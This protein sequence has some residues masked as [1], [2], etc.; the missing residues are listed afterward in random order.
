MSSTVSSLGMQLANSTIL[1]SEQANMS[2]LNGQL[3][4]GKKSNDLAEYTPGEALNLLNLNT[5]ITRREG[6]LSVINTISTR[7][8]VYDQSLTSLEGLAAEAASLTNTAPTYNAD[9][10]SSNAE[11]IIGFM[12]QAEYYLNQR[13]GD[14]YIFAGTRYD[15]VPVASIAALPVP[16]TEVAPYTTT[17]PDLPAYDADYATM[18]SSEEAYA[19]DSVSVDTTQSL[20]YGITSTQEP[21]QKLIMGLRFAYSATQDQ[22]NYETLMSTARDLINAGL[23]GVREVHSTLAATQTVL[24]QVEDR[25]NQALEDINGQISDIQSVDVNDV[26]VKINTLETQLEASYSVTATMAKLSII[27]Y[28]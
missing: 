16:P 10:N 3:A 20:Q 13:V 15:T 14:R 24:N 19:K 2:A 7:I 18:P 12:R 27:N 22:N 6:F 8:T 28:L 26:A 4:S 9:G 5:T 23:D 17:E 25:H 21:F 1:K 11:Q